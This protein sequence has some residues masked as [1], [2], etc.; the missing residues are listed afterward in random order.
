MG[1]TTAGQGGTAGDGRHDADRVTVFRGS[2]FFGE[3]T[4]VLVIHV[5]IHE[6][7]NFSFI[8][9]Q[10]LFQLGIR[11]GQAAKRLTHGGRVTFEAGLL[12]G[13]L[14]KRRWNHNLY[15]HTD[16]SPY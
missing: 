11:P 16:V 8:R 5:D 7:A 6:A 4:D 3:V 13:K 9:K 1:G 14:A 10:M 15:G 12:P 2:I